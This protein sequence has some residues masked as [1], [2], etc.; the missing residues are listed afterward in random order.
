MTRRFAALVI[1]L[2]T[3]GPSAPTPHEPDV[4]TTAGEEQLAE[5]PDTDVPDAIEP[6]P[7]TPCDAHPPS[8]ATLEPLAQ[9]GLI[10]VDASAPREL[11]T[12]VSPALVP[13]EGTIACEPG[14]MRCRVGDRVILLAREHDTACEPYALIRYPDTAPTTDP[15]DVLAALAHRD[16]ACA[17]HDRVALQ[18]PS[19]YE[20]TLRARRIQSGP[21]GPAIECLRD[22]DAQAFTTE[23]RARFAQVPLRCAGLRCESA[24]ESPSPAGILFA[25]RLSGP[26]RFDAVAWVTPE[27]QP[28]VLELLRERCR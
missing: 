25:N 20:P 24:A 23:A 7:P 26:L 13:R 27:D 17:V 10:V 21:R 12:C 8:T 3:C 28:R 14:S 19:F 9:R 16:E 11:G 6:P 15:D 1:A 22:A 18:D 5:V 4:V 2:S